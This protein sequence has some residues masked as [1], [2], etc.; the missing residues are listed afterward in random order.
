RPRSTT[1][2]SDVPRGAFLSGG[3]DSPT[4]SA[5]MQSMSKETINTCSIGFIPKEDNEAEHASAVARQG[6][7][8]HTAMY[9]TESDALDVMP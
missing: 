1:L 6:G 8:I 4:V 9:V 3:S 2:Q 5:L 7:T